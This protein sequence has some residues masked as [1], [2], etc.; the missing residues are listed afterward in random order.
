MT[1]GVIRQRDVFLE[2][3]ADAWF[4]RNHDA[5]AERNY[6]ED[7]LCRS[8]VEIYPT[9]RVVDKGP[10]I[11]E[12]G[13][14][15]GKRLAWIAS[16]LGAQV[17]GIDPSAKAVAE[18]KSMDLDVR[19]GT[20]ENL[21]W[22]DNSFDIVIF[23]FCLYLCD[24]EDLFRIAAEADRVIKPESW[25]LIQDFH[26]TGHTR[27]AYHHRPGIFSTKMDYRRLFDWHPAYTCYSHKVTA[28]GQSAFTDD[29]EEWVATSILRKRALDR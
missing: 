25:L 20:A 19:R 10:T 26:A 11:L 21:P 8:L 3:E 15:E 14:G 1:I 18:A 9:I 4:E 24:P 2:S 23:G 28:H 29:A 13:C 22:Q 27:R 17:N 12:I 7:Q 5:I 6:E 16:R